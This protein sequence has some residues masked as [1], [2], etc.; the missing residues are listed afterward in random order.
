LWKNSDASLPKAAIRAHLLSKL[1]LEGMMTPV[2]REQFAVI[3]DREVKHTPT[4]AS[5]SVYEYR[6]PAVDPCSTASINWSRG[7]DVLPN[8]DDYD[9]DEVGSHGMRHSS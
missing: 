3:S 6:D 4:G 7:G 1:E 5:F 8:G 9:R 2:K